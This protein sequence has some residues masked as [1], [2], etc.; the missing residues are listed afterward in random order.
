MNTPKI[1]P[2][3]RRLLVCLSLVFTGGLAGPLVQAQPLSCPAV[4]DSQSESKVPQNQ[5]ELDQ[6]VLELLRGEALYIPVRNGFVSAAEGTAEGHEYSSFLWWRDVAR[7]VQGLVAKA[8]LLRMTPGV[9]QEEREQAEKD[10]RDAAMGMVKIM[11]DKRFKTK[12]LANIMNPN[13]HMRPEGDTLVPETRTQTAPYIE[14]REPTEQEKYES[15]QWGHKQNDALAAFGNTLLDAING[16]YLHSS[17]VSGQAKLNLELLTTYLT[18]VQYWKM[19][20]V[21][22]WEE[23]H[24]F[25]NRT[26]SVGMVAGFIERIMKGL[27]AGEHRPVIPLDYFFL[28]LKSELSRLEAANLTERQRNVVRT[29]MTAETL[30]QAVSHGVAL[31]KS[32]L[33][34]NNRGNDPS[35]YEF[36]SSVAG[37][38]PRGADTAI[39]HILWHSP[40]ALSLADQLHIVEGLKV[41]EREHGYIRY[42]DDQYLNL[43]YGEAEWTLIDADLVS[44]YSDAYRTERNPEFLQKAK[45]HA[46]RMLSQITVEGALTTEGHPIAAGIV[47]EAF[48]PADA[49]GQTYKISPNSPL[50]WSTA[51]VIRALKKLREAYILADRR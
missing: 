5:A 40:S 14:D 35:F 8:E 28:D 50:N 27:Y 31:T 17:E 22:A 37:E 51:N 46:G 1:D 11:A 49:R 3:P 43:G 42:E 13:L 19:W 39:F 44:W 9:S 34:L 4:F 36:T 12:A 16:G 7:V 24:H 30:K 32:R 33:G 41:L 23:P 29:V 38:T 6:L 48:V 10:A 25:A 15:S 47:P 26:S 45:Y 21:G 2:T 20:D 18:R